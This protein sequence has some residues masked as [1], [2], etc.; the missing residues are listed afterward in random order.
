MEINTF[1]DIVIAA[2]IFVT[3]MGGLYRVWR[4]IQMIIELGQSTLTRL[5]RINGKVAEHD[6]E[7]REH[8]DYLVWLMGQAGQPLHPKEPRRE[9]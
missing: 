4:G 3:V 8:R 9:P 2:G 6:R 1:L 7:L 5:D